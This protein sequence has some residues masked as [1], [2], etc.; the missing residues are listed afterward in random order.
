MASP[1]AVARAA[2][3]V[4]PPIATATSE[5]SPAVPT[6]TATRAP[7]PTRQAARAAPGAPVPILMYHYIRENPDPNDTIGYGLSIPPPLFAAHMDFLLERGYRVVPMRGVEQVI[8]SGRLPEEKT[9][10]LTLDDGYRDAYTE[11]FPTLRA[12]GFGATVFVITDLIDNQRYLTV[13]QIRELSASGI[14]IGSH[15]ATH[16][17]LPSLSA[18]RLRHEVVDSRAVLERILGGPVTAFCYPSGRNSA[19]VRAAV[20]AAGYSSALTVEPGLFRGREDRFAIPR[21]RVYGGMGVASLAR[22]IGEPSPDPTR[23]RAFLNDV[24]APPP[25]RGATR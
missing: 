16:S 21:V 13:D 22:A 4:A 7:A 23:W 25:R 12:H 8:A 18:P 15:S 14:E 3:I 17:D 1:A 9:V 2:A 5:P 20:K 24:P 19:V 10:V 6:P 11:A